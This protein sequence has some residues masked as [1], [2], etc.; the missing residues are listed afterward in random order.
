MQL[1]RIVISDISDLQVVTLQ[2]VDGERKIPIIVG[3]FEASSINRRVKKENS[4]RPLTHDLIIG[5]IEQMG[6]TIDSIVICELVDQ[7]FYAKL[8]VKKDGEIIVIDSRPSDAIA[9]AVTADV[10]IFVEEEVFE[11]LGEVP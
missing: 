2:E 11:E 10:P 9:I 5:L 3:L 4:P 8:R 6:G 1:R 7:T